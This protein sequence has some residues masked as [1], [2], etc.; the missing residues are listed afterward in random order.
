M[1]KIPLLVDGRGVANKWDLV[2]VALN[3]SGCF[4]Q[5]GAG[6]LDRLGVGRGIGAAAHYTVK[7]QLL[8]STTLIRA[9]VV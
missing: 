8:L 4:I 2:R 3:L 9:K 6:F 1:D 7:A 5:V